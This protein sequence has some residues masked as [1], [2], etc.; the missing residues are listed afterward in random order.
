MS[1][2]SRIIRDRNENTNCAA[3]SWWSAPQSILGFDLLTATII[4]PHSIAPILR[5]FIFYF[6]VICTVHRPHSRV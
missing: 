6:P 2:I 5:F 3:G 4:H 1:G